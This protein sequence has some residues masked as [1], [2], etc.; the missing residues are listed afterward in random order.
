MIAIDHSQATTRHADKVRRLSI[1]FGN[2]EDATL[3]NNMRLSQVRTLVFWGVSKCMPYIMEFRL[4]KVIILHLWGDEDNISFDLAGISNL[5]RLRYLQV[6]SNVTLKLQ[7]HLQGLQYLETLKIDGK[8]VVVPSDI[9]HL[10]SLLH[11]N[12]PAKTNLPNGIAHMTSLRTLGF[13]DLSCNS[14]E[15]VWSL[16]KLT[17]LQDL[18]LVYSTARSNNRMMNMQMQC[19]GSILG[20]LSNLKFLTLSPADSSH[21]NT[22]TLLVASATSTTI[23]AHGLSIR[24]SSPPPLLQRL[25]LLPC[26][27]SKLPK[28]IGQLG[29]LCIL[30]ISVIEV[31]NTDVDVLGGLLALTVL[32]LY[33]LYEPAEWIV[34][35]GGGF[36]VLKYFKFACR[37][38]W[39]KFEA[40]AMPN[41]QKLKLRFDVR[42]PDQHGTIPVGIEHLSGLEEISAKAEVADDLC[43]RFVESALD[44]V[45]L[46]TRTF[47]NG[48]FD[49]H[50]RNKHGR[51]ELLM[52]CP[53]EDGF[54]WRKYG[55]REMPGAL[56]PRHYYRCAHV[57]SMCCGAL[58]WVQRTDGDPSLFKVVYVGLHTCSHEYYQQQLTWWESAASSSSQQSPDKQSSTP[59]E[60]E[61]VDTDENDFTFHQQISKHT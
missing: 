18:Q 5:F 48:C 28:W 39:L 20:N 47:E 45:W 21:A 43:K 6:T 56:H 35:K 36:L 23:F 55:Q 38:S 19:L 33:V 54:S 40:G 50:Y 44:K 25:E 32:L 14:T 16:G 15:N 53:A 52:S 27:F 10:P 2:V 26:M 22:N 7:T 41:L 49:E 31:A 42:R 8:L 11:L 51:K 57:N 37:V 30:K 24:V 12:L 9:I 34:F 13:F 1:Q 17:N 61:R 58:R 46:C 29:N 59:S 4:L 3:P 60:S